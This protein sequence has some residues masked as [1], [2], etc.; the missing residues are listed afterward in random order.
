M[1]KERIEEL[2]T[3]ANNHMKSIIAAA[4]YGTY[5]GTAV[6]EDAGHGF[7]DFDITATVTITG[8]SCH[9]AIESPP[10]VPYFINSY[11]GNSYSGVYLGLTTLA[12]AAAL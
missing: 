1:F 5:S 6:L 4:P 9:I 7:G 11:E 3:M 8:D 10:Q 2:L 12:V